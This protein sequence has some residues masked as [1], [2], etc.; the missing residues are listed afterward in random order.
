[1]ILSICIPTFNRIHC[2]K[3]CLNSIYISKKNFD[4]E[5]EICI[6][7][8]CSTEDVE[9]VIDAYKN[10]INIKFKKSK[11]N[12]GGGK[13]QIESVSM[14][15]GEYVWIIGNDELL[16]PDALK[17]LYQLI[18]SNSEVD[19]FFINAYEMDSKYIFNSNQPFDTNN[20]PNNMEKRSKLNVSKNLEFFELIK[21]NV[22]FDFLLGTYLA[23]FKRKKWVENLHVIDETLINDSRTFSNFDNTCPHIKIWSCAFSKSKAYYQA[24]PLLVAL[25]GEREWVNL[26][27]Y[28]EIIRL[29]EALDLYKKRGLPLL[30]Y[31]YC[32]NYAL[33]NFTSYLIKVLFY[34]GETGLKYINFKKH[35][36][37]NLIFPNVYLSFF[38]FIFRK[39]LKFTFQKTK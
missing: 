19:Y 6:S 33:R 30:Q 39:I 11:K 38:Y 8:N 27:N 29:P 14:A 7:D 21:P 24:D 3:N 10:K 15:K 31:L 2:L 26:Y 5:F 36:F 37:K 18:N 22:T 28:I 1:M 4:Y 34:K 20:F 12:F 17:R 9:K 35:I 16:L 23:V 25:K 32:K 13:N